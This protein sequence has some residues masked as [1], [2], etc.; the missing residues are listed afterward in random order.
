MNN[1]WRTLKGL[2]STRPD[3]RSLEQRQTGWLMGCLQRNRDCLYGKRHGFEQIDSIQAYRKRVPLV[4]YEELRQVIER[5]AQGEADLLF[6]GR[7]AAFEQTGG[8]SGGSKLIPYTTHSLE[9]FQRGILPWL[10]SLVSTYELTNGSIYLALSPATRQPQTTAGGIPIGLPDTAYLGPRAGRALMRLSALPGWVGEIPDI[11]SWRLASLYWLVRRSDLTLIS[12][13]SPSFMLRLLQGLTRQQDRLTA[14]LAYGG[15]LGEHRLPADDAAL[16]RYH[17]YLEDR[18]SRLLWP[19]LRVVSCWMDGASRPFAERLQKMLP[20]AHFQGKGLLATEGV[21][22]VPDSSGQPV[23]TAD[24]GF[25]EFLDS[26]GKSRCAWE[27]KPGEEYELVL[28][29][30]GGLYRYRTGDLV[31]FIR[32]SKDLPVLRFLGRN[33]LI[34]DLVGEKLNEAFVAQCLGGIPGFN[35]L[36]P[37]TGEQPHYTL[38][39]D[40]LD[41][42]RSERLERLEQ[43]LQAN[44]QYAYARKLGQLAPLTPTFHPAPLDIYIKNA[45]PQ[46]RL[47]EI[48][49]PA[50]LPPSMKAEWFM[51][52]PF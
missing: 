8:S 34:S 14:L 37:V 29:N 10:A 42:P 4:R 27:L 51:A 2:A 11:D 18:E 33:D 7:P 20:Q 46:Q 13:W 49:I 6:R 23:L 24:S 12:V 1:P 16:V 32:M 5:I 44:P 25:Y 47:G 30:A 15:K 39:T 48:K 28:T 35:M 52:E 22:T 17:R 36:A 19:L 50:L 3:S 38:I 40:H 21:S 26:T 45:A 43:A 31:R 9:D 41:G